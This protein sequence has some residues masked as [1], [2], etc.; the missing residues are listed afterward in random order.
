LFFNGVDFCPT[1]SE[2]RDKLTHLDHLVK[3]QEGVE[4]RLDDG[5]DCQLKDKE[6]PEYPHGEVCD[7]AVDRLLL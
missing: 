3:L 1:V 4:R 6:K 5:T 7:L 2:C